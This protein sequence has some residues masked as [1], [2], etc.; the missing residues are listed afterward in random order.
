LETA[1]T[2]PRFLSRKVLVRF[3]ATITVFGV[4]LAVRKVRSGKIIEKKALLGL[5]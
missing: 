5:L 3:S 4:L 2:R 1:L